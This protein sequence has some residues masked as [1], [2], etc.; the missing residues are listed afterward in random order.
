MEVPEK[1]GGLCGEPLYLLTLTFKD[2]LEGRDV[3]WGGDTVNN[4]SEYMDLIL[5]YK[6]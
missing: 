4:A 5:F 2:Q 6:Q 3:M 1:M